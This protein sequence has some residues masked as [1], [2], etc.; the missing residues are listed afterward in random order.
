MN[1][2]LGLG[3]IS[4]ALDSNSW[5]LLLIYEFGARP[6]HYGNPKT[7]EEIQWYKRFIVLAQTIA[8]T[9]DIELSSK[10]RKVLADNFRSL[11]HHSKLQKRLSKLAKNLNDQR[12]WLEGRRAIKKIM[13]YDHDT[14]RNGGETEE[15][16]QLVGLDEALKPE[17]LV[18]KIRTYVLNANLELFLHKNESRSGSVPDWQ[19]LDSRAARIAHCLGTNFADYPKNSDQLWQEIFTS[20]RSYCFN[21]G[22]GLATRNDDLQG[23]WNNLVKHLRLVGNGATNYE[24]FCG[25]I[26]V[27]YKCD[28][29]LARSILDDAVQD[30][31][32]RNFIVKLHLS[33]PFEIESFNRLLKSL[34]FENI[35]LQQFTIIAW[36][37]CTI[38]VLSDADIQKLFLKILDKPRGFEFVVEGLVMR[39][40]V[41]KDDKRALGSD[42]KRL[43]LNVSV[44]ILREQKNF[45]TLDDVICNRLQELLESCIDD[46]EFV[47]E[48]TEVLDA[49]F[50]L[51]IESY[52]V[53]ARLDEL[54]SVLINELPYLFLDRIFLDARIDKIIIRNYFAERLSIKNP[55]TNL[56]SEILFNWCQQGDFEERLL[57]ISDEIFPYENGKKRYKVNFTEQAVSILNASKNPLNVLENYYKSVRP[58]SWWGSMADIV[59]GRRHAFESLLDSERSDIRGAAEIV[60]AKLIYLENYERRGEQEEYNSEQTFE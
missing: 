27:I 2:L 28:E 38:N 37:D 11:W 3:M 39:A 25:V 59:N 57:M 43:G 30:P 9:D 23:L 6:R 41:I 60:I 40:Y 20:T 26:E 14:T 15:F 16:Q 29:N 55:L 46:S 7:H 51:L 53:V 22:K 13:R 19:V 5:S 1:Q 56:D 54:G 44:N 12:P 42:L 58:N 47:V 21:F 49:Y 24:V 50:N 36:S 32:L 33:V 4:V 35:P 8:T 17:T 18:D 52:G 34:D 48:S 10:A 31:M 45:T